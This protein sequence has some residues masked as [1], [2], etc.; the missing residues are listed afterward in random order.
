MNVLLWNRG[1]AIPAV[2][3]AVILAAAQGCAGEAPEGCYGT[4]RVNVCYSPWVVVRAEAGYSGVVMRKG[5][6]ADADPICRTDN[7]P[8]VIPVGGHFGRCSLRDGGVENGCP[9][10]GARPTVNGFVWGYYVGYAKQGWIPYNVGGTAYSVEDPGWS[11]TLCGPAKFD[12]DCRY[13]GSACVQYHG[14]GGSPV[15]ATIP[16]SGFHRVIEVGSTPGALSQ[17]KYYLR[18]AVNSTTFLWLVPG[19]TVRRHCTG[20][21]SGY[22]WSCVTVI[23]A[24]Y[25][26]YGCRGWIRSD[27]LGPEIGEEAAQPCP[28]AVPC[29]DGNAFA[30]LTCGE[31]KLEPD[32]SPVTLW[33]KVVTRNLGDRFAIAEPD[34]SAGLLVSGSTGLAP[35]DLVDVAGTLASLPSGERVVEQAVVSQ[36]STGPEPAPVYV[37]NCAL[38]GGVWGVHSPGVDGEWRMHN[39]GCLV[40]VWGRVVSTGS[41]YFCLSDGSITP[42]T[43][44]RV[45]FGGLA[46]PFVGQFVSASGISGLFLSG[47]SRQRLLRVSRA[48]DI[49]AL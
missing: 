11:G 23:C 5:P 7:S 12:F 21:M 1:W 37:T 20:N 6:F 42:D 41:G 36:A 40:T 4:D 34:R 3:A 31:V 22:N 44:V 10:P 25:A 2:V 28:A 47:G 19:D 30:N 46:Q 48:A 8:V 18:Y 49:L 15:P 45:E 27:A 26:P 29:P 17:E 38:G 9:D 39:V 13:P 35:G 32:G 16:Q 24:K 14:C 43:G 33:A